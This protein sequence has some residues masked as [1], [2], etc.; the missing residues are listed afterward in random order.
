MKQLHALRQVP[1]RSNLFGYR[2]TAGI[3]V[4]GRAAA[5]TAFLDFLMAGR[6]VRQQ[7]PRDSLPDRRVTR[8]EPVL[9]LNRG[10]GRFIRRVALVPTARKNISAAASVR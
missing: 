2:T 5:S 1:R 9:L 7:R 8:P 10:N 4:L 3:A 6:I